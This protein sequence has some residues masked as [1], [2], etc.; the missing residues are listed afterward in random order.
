MIVKLSMW[1]AAASMALLSACASADKKTLEAEARLKEVYPQVSYTAIRPGP[2]DGV[3]EVQATEALFYFVPAK[4]LLLFG[5]F[6]TTGGTSL[7]AERR[8]ELSIVGGAKSLE[9]TMA[10][11]GDAESPALVIRDGSPMVTAFLDIHCGHCKDAVA[12]LTES[13]R[14]GGLE[15]IFLSRTK[16]DADQAAHAVCA[17]EHLRS[18]ALRQVFG[19]GTVEKAFACEGALDRLASQARVAAELGVEATPVFAVNQ[20]VLLGFHPDRLSSLLAN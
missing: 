19:G 7:T 8:S 20:Q 11:Q 12:W 14:K 16:A 6:F 15:V 4:D 1:V 13:G 18:A 3:Y 17:P 2:A 9:T 5:E 10:A